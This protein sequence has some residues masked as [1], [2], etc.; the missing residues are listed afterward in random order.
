MNFVHLWDIDIGSL[1][2]WS[3]T[4]RLLAWV[5]LVVVLFGVF[6]VGVLGQDRDVQV[7]GSGR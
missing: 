4:F 2:F 5:C 1:S 3:A 6:G 7:F